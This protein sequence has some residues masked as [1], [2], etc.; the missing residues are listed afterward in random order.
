MA[1]HV[2]AGDVVALHDVGHQRDQRLDLRVGKGLVA[3]GVTG[4][5]EFDADAVVI[6]VGDAAPIAA[7]GMPGA[8]LLRHHPHHLSGLGHQIVA[9]NLGYRIAQ[10]AQRPPPTQHVG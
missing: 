9:R 6:H 10:P 2:A 5:V 8:P 4:I 3:V 1:D 7:P